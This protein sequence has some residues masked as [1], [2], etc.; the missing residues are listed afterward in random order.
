MTRLEAVPSND[1][2]SANIHNER[3]TT[4]ELLR[5]AV[6][7]TGLIAS[8]VNTTFNTTKAIPGKTPDNEP[9]ITQP[10]TSQPSVGCS[11]LAARGRYGV[12]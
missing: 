8:S 6:D 10:V 3:T 9:H 11:I 5:K 7:I 2:R 4:K 12:S 1:Y